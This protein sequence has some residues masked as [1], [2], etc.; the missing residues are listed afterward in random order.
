MG[1]SRPGGPAG[2]STDRQV[3]DATGTRRWQARRAGTL[4]QPS[5]GP[6]DLEDNVRHH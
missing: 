2:S 3:G 6:S 4:A 1:A 5:V